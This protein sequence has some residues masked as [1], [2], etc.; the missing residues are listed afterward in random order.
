MLISKVRILTVAHVSNVTGGINPV[1][2]I[3]AMGHAK[4]IPVIVD[5]AQAVPHFPVDVRDIGCEFYAGSGH[6]MGGPSS[7]GFLYG[8]ADVM[9]KLP[10][11]DGGSTMAAKVSFDEMV[12]KPI[13]QKYE[14][15]EPAF[16]E[17]EAWGAAIDYWRNLGL[18]SIAAYEKE[19][20]DYALAGMQQ[21]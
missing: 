12:P 19:L 8:R 18:D 5:G 3:T 13:P 17:V 1:K 4:G 15:G 21:V 7:V 6:K 2:K 9:E 11:S 14:A 20:T 16:G 10:A